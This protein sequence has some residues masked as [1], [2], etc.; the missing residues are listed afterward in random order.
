MP[1]RS[2]YSTL[3]DQAYIR[4]LELELEQLKKD[5]EHMKVDIIEL[6]SRG[7]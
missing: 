5:I 6:R 3:P 2:V 7:L 4:V 1:I